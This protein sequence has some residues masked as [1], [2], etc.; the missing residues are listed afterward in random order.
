MPD[1]ISQMILDFKSKAQ[2]AK[3]KLV[4]SSH[5]MDRIRLITEADIYRTCAEQLEQWQNDITKFHGM[6][7]LWG[8][9]SSEQLVEEFNSR[10]PTTLKAHIAHL[11]ITERLRERGN[12]EKEI[13]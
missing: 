4:S 1:H 7:D 11:Q 6:E 12:W 9:F 8:H 3:D 10:Y 13:S 5:P 2:K